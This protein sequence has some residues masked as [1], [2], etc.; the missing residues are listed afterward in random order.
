MLI[1]YLQGRTMR[2]K[3]HGE[4]SSERQ[5]NGGVAQGSTFGIWQYLGQSNSN[6]DCVPND[7]KFKFVDDL[8][9][10][11]KINLLMVGLSSHNSRYSVPNDVLVNNQIIKPENLKSQEYLDK[12]QNWTQEQKNDI[13]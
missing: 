5:L 4:L 11:E 13:K 8:S 12:I 2:V 1:S 3:W 7:Y 10:L 6:A 9:V